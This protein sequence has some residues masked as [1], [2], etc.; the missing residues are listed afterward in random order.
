MRRFLL[1]CIAQKP[2]VADICADLIRCPPQGRQAVQML[3]QHHFEQYHRV[4]AGS[5][6]IFTVQRF[7]HFIEPVKIYRRI[8]FSQQMVFRH[9]A[10]CIDNLY[11]TTIHFSAFQHLSS[12][13]TILSYKRKKAQPLLDFFDRLKRPLLRALFRR[14]F[15]LPERAYPDPPTFHRL[16]QL[17]QVRPA[18]E[19]E[20]KPERGPLLQGISFYG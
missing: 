15:I 9:Q 13:R 5:S 3:D 1:E 10:L 11:D 18:Q 14:S 12:P 17:L 4:Y 6:V 16:Q 2:T 19:W 20:R 8:Y 7:H